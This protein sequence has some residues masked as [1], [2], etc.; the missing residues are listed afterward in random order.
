MADGLRAMF[1]RWL[2]RSGDAPRA[3]RG[4]P[5]APA[6]DM[7]MLDALVASLPD[8]ALVL[9]RDGRVLSFNAAAR[10][11]APALARGQ[12][13]SLALRVPEVVEAMREVA[14]G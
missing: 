4:A 2:S 14:G 8:G 10:V 1:G 5:N 9:D 13:A 3:V 7:P 6:A 11:I 12:P